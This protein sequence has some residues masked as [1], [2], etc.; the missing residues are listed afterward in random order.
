MPL[1]FLHFRAGGFVLAR[2]PRDVDAIKR[3]SRSRIKSSHSDF[4][5]SSHCRG[6]RFQVAQEGGII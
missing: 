6:L 1:E 3:Q 5:A 2:Q 4:A